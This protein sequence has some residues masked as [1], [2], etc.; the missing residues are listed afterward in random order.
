MVFSEDK[1]VHGPSSASTG[2]EIE[3]ERTLWKVGKMSCR[4]RNSLGGKGV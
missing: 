4:E 2:K 1:E 3:H